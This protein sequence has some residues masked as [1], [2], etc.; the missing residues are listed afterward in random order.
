MDTG[1]PSRETTNADF[2]VA[3]STLARQYGRDLLTRAAAEDLAQDLVLEHLQRLDAGERFDDITSLDAYVRTIVRT[4][5]IDALRRSRN[6]ARRDTEHAR[7]VDVAPAWMS[8][9]LALEERE[10][11]AMHRQTMASLP[12]ECRR[13]FTLVRER[14][15]SYEIAAT[16]LGVSRSAVNRHVMRA[17]HAFRRELREYGIDAPKPQRRATTAQGGTR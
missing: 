9:E 10:L 1:S 16:R 8:P 15:L 14:E 12:P 13:A 3:L 17:H 11:D 7:D 6:S 2:L 4:R 5:S